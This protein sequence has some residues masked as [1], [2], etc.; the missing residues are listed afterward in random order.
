MSK[1]EKT[2]RNRGVEIAAWPG[3]YGP[4]FTW[5]K[6]YKDKQTGEYKVAKALF[7]EDLKTLADLAEEAY[8]WAT[9]SD[10]KMADQVDAKIDELVNKLVDDLDIPF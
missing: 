4:Q 1:P 2:W 7:K 5:R 10:R 3:N 8:Q 9:S 6:T